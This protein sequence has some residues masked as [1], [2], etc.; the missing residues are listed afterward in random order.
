MLCV[1]N[2]RL[3]RRVA[4]VATVAAPIKEARPALSTVRLEWAAKGR[5][6]QPSVT[7]VATDSYKLIAYEVDEMATGDHGYGRTS[8]EADGVTTVEAEPLRK[9]LEKA[10]SHATVSDPEGMV[11]ITAEADSPVMVYARHSEKGEVEVAKLEPAEYAFPQWRKLIPAPA[12]RQDEGERV[13]LNPEYL[14]QL[15]AAYRAGRVPVTDNY[16]LVVELNELRPVV[17][18]PNAAADGWLGLLMPVRL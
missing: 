12:K 6:D 14:A 15:I 9:A 10:A 1:L 3:A 2:A 16:P 7:F 13:G 18:R 11:V 17:L 4:A 8:T 5:N